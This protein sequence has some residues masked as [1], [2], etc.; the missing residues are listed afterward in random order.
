MDNTGRITVGLSAA[1]RKLCF[2]RVSAAA[3]ELEHMTQVDRAHVLMLAEQG[4]LAPGAARTLLGEIGRLR[5]EGFASLKSRPS[6]RGLYLL[7]EDYLIETLGPAVGGNLQLGRSRN[8]LNATVLRLRLRR[9]LLRLAGCLLRLWRVLLRQAR[10]YARVV[11]PVYTHHQAALP[12]TFGHYL[13][14]LAEALGRDVGGLLEAATD[15][16]RCPLGAGAAGGTSVP[17]DP[18][19]TARLLGFTRAVRHSLDAV[20]SRDLVLR[21]L[22]ATAIAGTTLSRLATDLLLWTTAEFAFLELPDSLVGSSSM[23]PQK[24]NPFVLEHVQGRAGTALGA[25]VA[26]ATAMHAT[27]FTNSIAV[28]CE[29]VAH[30]WGPLREVA[31]AAV[32]ARLIVAEARP[33]PRAMLRRAT[34]GHVCATELANRLAVQGGLP[35]REAH[36]VVGVLVRETLESGNNPLADAA[37]FWQADHPRGPSVDLQGLEPEAVAGAAEY[38]GGPGTGALTRALKAGRREWSALRDRFRRLARRWQ[39]AEEE[40]ETTARHFEQA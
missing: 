18:Q 28:G 24:R 17:I 15:L 40:L 23:M 11:M 38:G 36:H 22:S 20:A 5:A 16:D 13:A 30:V 33:Q 10:R 29:A 25:F 1:V 32:L 12:I 14:G 34:E 8:D 2:G 7:Y 35:Y 37:Q 39:E 31:K 6:T 27:P 21:L 4:L 9:P 3:D 26:A 19:R